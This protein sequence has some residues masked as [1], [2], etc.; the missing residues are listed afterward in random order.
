MNFYYL[1]SG[2][3][4]GVVVAR[5][6]IHAIEVAVE[7]GLHKTGRSVICLEIDRT[8]LSYEVLK[9]ARLGSGR[10]LMPSIFREHPI[11]LKDG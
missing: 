1:R 6:K 9:L 11:F 2:F 10:I 4:V 5:N 3:K 8:T 7:T